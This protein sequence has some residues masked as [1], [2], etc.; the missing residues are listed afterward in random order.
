MQYEEDKRQQ[1]LL[2]EKKIM[3]EEQYLRNIILSNK[4]FHK[5][6]LELQKENKRLSTLK[7]INKT[8][9]RYQ[10]EIPPTPICCQYNYDT[11]QLKLLFDYE[12]RT[13]EGI[14]VPQ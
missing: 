3:E 7:S 6:N 4:E 12:E 5:R 1:I 13:L 2:L 14:V 11:Q 8:K 10:F 9:K